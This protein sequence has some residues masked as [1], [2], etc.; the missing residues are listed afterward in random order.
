MCVCLCG[1]P[2]PLVRV[3]SVTQRP[4][5]RTESCGLAGS[6]SPKGSGLW[7]EAPAA[8]PRKQQIFPGE[9][10]AGLLVRWFHP[11]IFHKN[12]VLWFI[13]NEAAA[14][15]LIR[16]N[17]REINI[18]AIAQFSHLLFHTFHCRVWVEWIDSSSNP[19][20]GL[21]RLGLDDLWTAAQDSDVEDFP[22]PQDL[23]PPTFLNV[24]LDHMRVAD[25]G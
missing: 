7:W 8:Y 10:L 9:A 4:H 24:F 11:D 16:G 13:D 21:S 22:F 23:L 5:S 14:S 1:S 6:A 2:K 20:D 3:Y 17:S 25:S 18:H 12:D 19:S 15:C